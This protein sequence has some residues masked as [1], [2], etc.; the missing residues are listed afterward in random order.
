MYY[1]VFGILTLL[2]LVYLYASSKFI[3]LPLKKYSLNTFCQKQKYRRLEE[4]GY[5]S[6]KLKAKEYLH[7]EFPE[8]KTAKVI[9]STTDPNSLKNVKLP[10]KYV[11][12]YSTGAR[13]FQI[14]NKGDD[15]S[16]L[17]KQAKYF[18]SI[19]FSNYGY[20]SIPFLGLE[21]PHYDFNENPK[22]FIEEYLEGIKEF[23]I[24]MAKGKL[25]YLE[26][27]ID[28]K[29]QY[30]DNN[31]EVIK[32]PKHNTL[33]KSSYEEK[34][35]CLDKILQFCYDFYEKEKFNLVRM[36]FYLNE[37]EDDFYLGEFTFT[38][39]NCRRKI[40]DTFINEHKELF[41]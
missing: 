28:N 16:K 37:K 25:L 32:D 6:D 21:E 9:Y 18:M 17:I 27:V 2:I 22:I 4:K 15:I 20:R 7:K 33:N 24:M 31:W 26:K 29:M 3:E 38:P 13:M 8:I 5:F 12:K 11:M 10:D 39:E 35:K 36:D 23:R 1:Y 41:V 14:G 40:S 30:F 19:K 34:P